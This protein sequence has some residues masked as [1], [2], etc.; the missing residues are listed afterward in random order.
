MSINHSKN[1]RQKTDYS[2]NDHYCIRK[3]MGSLK[4]RLVYPPDD[5]QPHESIHIL[6]KFYETKE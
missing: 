2:E 1:I 6:R 5:V 4:K 3:M